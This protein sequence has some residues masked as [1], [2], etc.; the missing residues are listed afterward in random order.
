MSFYQPQTANFMRY[1]LDAN[2]SSKLR[3]EAEQCLAELLHSNSAANASSV[4]REGQAARALITKS[5]KSIERFI[6]ANERTQ[7][8]I[9]FT[10]GGTEACN[11]LIHGFV[12]GRYDKISTNQVACRVV[13]SAIEHQAV[14]EPLRALQIKQVVQVTEVQPESTGR[15][16]PGKFS[17]AITPNTVC[18]FLMAANNVTGTIQPIVQTAQKIREAKFT[19]AIVCDASQAFGKSDFSAAAAFNAGVDAIVLSGH[20]LGAPQGIGA[21]IFSPREDSCKFF[22]PLLVG[23]GQ[24]NRFR[25]GTENLFGIAALGAVLD[26]SAESWAMERE[27]LAAYRD[28][29][30]Q[31]LVEIYPACRILSKLSDSSNLSADQSEVG[32]L[33]NTLAVSFPGISAQD[34]VVALDLAGLAV[35]TGSACASGKQ[36]TS[37]VF[38]TLGLDP[39]VSAGALRI[40][41]DWDFKAEM[42]PE[43][44]KIFA[45]VLSRFTKSHAAKSKTMTN[46][47]QGT[48]SSRTIV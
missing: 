11:S 4:H 35:S 20:K 43:V 48:I 25:S 6:F 1:Y 34:L 32:T 13:A 38:D 30:A 12:G 18:C 31:R 28:E 15:I 23:G 29:L 40:S 9:V 17:Q 2:A 26:R 46:A 14:L 8:N 5:R 36:E 22:E 27:N 44:T 45:Q 37:Y 33:V 39:E 21:I 7:A 16:D 41:L 19:A 47:T 10:S 3:P 24:E 42:I